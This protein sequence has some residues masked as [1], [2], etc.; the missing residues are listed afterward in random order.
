[1]KKIFIS[2][3]RAEAE[4]AAGALARELRDHFGDEQVFRDKED[5]GGGVA[6]KQEIVSEINP[7]AAMLVL[8]GKDWL[9]AKNSQS[10]RRLDAADDPIRMEIAGGLVRGARVIPVLLENAV[11]PGDADLPQD[12]QGLTQFNA[13]QLRDSDWQ[14]DMSKILKTLE[15]TGFASLKKDAPP[16]SAT[17]ADPGPQRRTDDQSVKR[18]VSGKLIASYVLSG[19]SFIAFKETHDR[20]T[21]QGLALFGLIA[22]VLAIFAYRDFRRGKV[23]GPWGSYGAIGLGALVALGYMGYAVD[24][25]QEGPAGAATQTQQTA[26]ALPAA[27]LPTP[28]AAPAAIPATLPAVSTTKI[29]VEAKREVAPPAVVTVTGHWKDAG[30]GASIFLNQDGSLVHLAANWQGVAVEGQGMLANGELRMAVGAAG[31][32]AGNLQLFLAPDGR[33]LRGVMVTQ[34]GTQQILFLR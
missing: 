15:K 16:G 10:Q 28:N 13:L 22:L 23:S 3:R 18:G 26:P 27:A 2:Y 7:Q 25:P 29:S 8:I 33:S 14:Y 31:I 11:M 12:L 6:W 30:D 9:V 20:S 19:L 32:P 1:M 17:D 21:F 24:A 34:N 5:I 4:Y